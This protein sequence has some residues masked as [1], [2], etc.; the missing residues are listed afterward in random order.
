MYF[1]QSEPL[2][3]PHS[4]LLWDLVGQKIKS[5]FFS[6]FSRRYQ[7]DSFHGA[8]LQLSYTNWEQMVLRLLQFKYL[9][10][11]L[12]SNLIFFFFKRP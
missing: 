3:A 1:L 5:L 8:C 9:G 10:I 6:I 11:I 2:F 7:A 4:G 12:G